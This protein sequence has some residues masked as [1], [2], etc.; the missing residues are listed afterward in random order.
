MGGAIKKV[1]VGAGTVL[2]CV[3]SNPVPKE[4]ANRRA[5]IC[6]N[7]P[8]NGKGDFTSWFTV[9]LAE[10]IRRAES[11]LKEQNLT[12]EHDDKIKVCQACLCPLKLKV[13]CQLSTL[14]EHMIPEVLKD[15]HPN[16]WITK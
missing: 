8:E 3:R 15:L 14:K 16:C 13:H 11:W 9:P 7:C 1:A 10:T 6:A 12:T 5:L 4:E 2:D